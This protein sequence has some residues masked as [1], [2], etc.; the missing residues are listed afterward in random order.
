[1]FLL[2]ATQEARISPRPQGRPRQRDVTR[3]IVAEQAYDIRRL[4]MENELLRDFLQ[5]QDNFACHKKHGLPAEIR[6][7][8]KWQQMSQQVHKYENLLNRNFRC[9]S[10]IF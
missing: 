10:Y 2:A 8:R 1:M 6:C 4:R 3:D 7:R 9:T 5:S